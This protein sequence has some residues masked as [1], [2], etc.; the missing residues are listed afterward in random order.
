MLRET[1]GHKLMPKKRQQKKHSTRF[2]AIKKTIDRTKVYSA[3]EAIELCKQT[4]TAK[5][6]ET[7][8]AHFNLGINPSKG[9]QQVRGTVVLPHSFGATKK[10]AAFVTEAK[11]QEA[12]DN[13]ADFVYTEADITEFQKNPKLDFDIAIAVP[14]MMKVIAPL[15]RLL[16]PKGLMPSPKN[17]TV[18]TNL[19]KTLEEV[20]KGKIAFKNDVGAN[21]HIGIGKKSMDSAALLENYRVIFEAVAKAKPETSKG[22]FLKNIVMAATMGPGVKVEL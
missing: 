16:G 22:N 9:D 5:F 7:I 2:T 13:G 21:L 10:V 11:A 1:A 18:S 4:S 6:D 17:E 3:A 19:K 20:K 8:E 12:K 15:A 14:D